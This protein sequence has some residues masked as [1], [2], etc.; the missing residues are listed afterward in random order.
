MIKFWTVEDTGWSGGQSWFKTGGSEMN[1]LRFQSHEL[2]LEYAQTRKAKFNQPTTLWRVVETT[3]EKTD[4]RE[5][6][7]REWIIV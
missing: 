1:P 3:I 7:T 2:A 5:V 4:N 6:T